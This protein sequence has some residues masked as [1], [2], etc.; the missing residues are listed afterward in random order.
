MPELIVQISWS[1]QCLDEDQ[2]IPW[3]AGLKPSVALIW[4]ETVY[5]HKRRMYAFRT[6]C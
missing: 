5:F 2:A 6:L 3:G 1:Q 4:P